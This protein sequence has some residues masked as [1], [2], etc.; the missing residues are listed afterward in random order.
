LRSC[1]RWKT[2]AR[3]G[4]R[5]KVRPLRCMKSRFLRHLRLWRTVRSGTVGLFPQPNGPHKDSNF[6]DSTDGSFEYSGGCDSFGPAFDPFTGPDYAS[7]DLVSFSPEH[8]IAHPALRSLTSRGRPAA[9]PGPLPCP[10]QPL[11]AAA[12]PGSGESVVQSAMG[13]QEANLRRPSCGSLPPQAA[14]LGRG[15]GGLHRQAGARQ[16]PLARRRGAGSKRAV[17]R[18]RSRTRPT[19]G[20]SRTTG[21]RWR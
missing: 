7:A 15:A 16:R 17:A 18:T 20:P 11:S 14:S 19:A 1:H 8:A 12:P 4:H 9:V 13:P 10:W 2:K 6:P 21:R 5:G 3:F